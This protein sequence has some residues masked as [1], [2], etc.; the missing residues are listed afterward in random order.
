MSYYLTEKID[1]ERHNEE[2]GLLMEDF[3]RQKNERVPVIISGSI[4][5]LLSNPE[6]NKTGHTFKDFFTKA[7]A[8][9]EC[10]LAYQYYAR[11]NLICDNQ[12]GLP[13][14]GWQLV[15]DFQN[16]YDRGWFGCPFRYFGDEDV[17]DTEEILKENS[18]Q[19]YEA[20]KQHGQYQFHG[21]RKEADRW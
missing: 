20:G 19:L 12:M 10:Q 15:L 7:E 16:S 6:I 14:R 17:P 11:H 4:R 8:Q 18:K 3:R 5:N 2:V 9:L 21:N 1:F 13:E